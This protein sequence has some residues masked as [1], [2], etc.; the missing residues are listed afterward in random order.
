MTPGQ[1]L[2]TSRWPGS[3]STA[4]LV[5]QHPGKPAESAGVCGWQRVL[6]PPAGVCAMVVLSLGVVVIIIASPP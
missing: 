4:V 5:V 6:H 1:W 2:I 3:P